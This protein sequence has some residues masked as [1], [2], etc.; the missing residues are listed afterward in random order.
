MESRHD[1]VR[2]YY[3]QVTA[4]DIGGVARDL[5]G[6]RIT[7]Q[8]GAELHCDCPHHESV[9]KRSLH[10][11][12]DQGLWHCFGCGIGGD[13]LQ[14]VEF[15]E[16]G[17]VT[18]GRRG[19]MTDAHR[20]A[21]DWLA[22]RVGLPPLS[23]AVATPEDAARVEAV[24]RDG[25]AVFAALTDLADAYHRAL[26][27][28][29]D[30]LEWLR[31]GWGIDRDVCARL[32]VGWADDR[33]AFPRLTARGHSPAAVAGTGAFVLRD[34]RPTPFFDHRVVFP[35]WRGGRVVY[36][37][38]RRTPWSPDDVE[39]EMGKYK[40]LQ[41]HSDR[42]PYVSPVIDNGVLMGEDVLL[43]RPDH[44][45]LA[46]GVTDW[47][48]AREMGFPAISPVT[49][50]L[51]ADDLARLVEKLRGCGTLY[52][53]QDNELSGVGLDGAIRSAVAL[54]EA[55]VRCRIGILPVGPRQ[56]AARA[57]LADM[58]GGPD[59]LDRIVH[60]PIRERKKAIA[61]TVAADDRDRAHE[62]IDE[63]KIDL[64]QWRRDG[65][66]AAGLQAVL[67][68]SKDATEAA[69]ECVPL[70]PDDEPAQVR[71]LDPVLR[72]LARMRAVDAKH[73]LEAI[74]DRTGVSLTILRKSVSEV[75]KV[76]Q[77]EDR[78]AAVGGR[79]PAMPPPPPPG[80][81]P[82][83]DSLAVL[84]QRLV[85]S[86]RA[87]GEPTP[88]EIMAEESYRWFLAHGARFFRTFD[89]TPLL[90]WENEVW[91]MASQAVGPRHRYQGLMHR[92]TGMVPT[93]TGPRTYYGALAAIA[94]DRGETREDFRWIESD[95]GGCTVWINCNNDRNEIVEASTAGARVLL[96][97]A[98]DAGV[99]LRGDQ[100]F[101]P[102]DFV[103]DVDHRDLEPVLVD[104]VGQHL[105]CTPTARRVLT[106]WLLAFPL[107]EFVGTRP[108]VRLEG[109]PGSGKTWAAK[110]LTT[111][112]YGADAQKKATDA[113]NWVDAARNPVLALDNVETKNTTDGLVDFLLTAITGIV[114]EKRASNTDSGVVVE[115][116][117]C[118]ILSTGVEPL[119][120][121]LEEVMSRSF[122][123]EF[124][125][126]L[127]GEILL[128][129][130]TLAAIADRRDW[131][132]SAIMHRASAVLDLV[133][134][135]AHAEVMRAMRRDLGD[136]GKR[137]CEEYLA[138]MYLVEVAGLS[139]S[140]HAERLVAIEDGFAAC[141]SSMADTTR[142][143]ARDAS[144]VA[145]VL[146]H[147][148]AHL[149][150]SPTSAA[151]ELGLDGHVDSTAR[152]VRD[153][154]AI[155]LLAALQMVRRERGAP[156]P[157]TNARQFG[158]R[159]QAADRLLAEQGF[160]L[161]SDRGRDGA[162]RYTIRRVSAGGQVTE[163]GPD[164]AVDAAG[165]P[166]LPP[167]DRA[168]PGDPAG[169]GGFMP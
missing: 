49:A 13:V 132:L 137:R 70:H 135:G 15:V 105:A 35:Y 18:A 48:A 133:R 5:L 169:G 108:M 101:L 97:G 136:H 92:L 27:D 162:N 79:A 21:R 91:Y 161:T 158:R 47:I 168:G 143:T 6:S 138:L 151:R 73:Y 95:V 141:V 43:G 154:R 96:N 72:E 60:L 102:F 26:L 166:V 65:G 39:W 58:L 76:V 157:W 52:L 148:F 4:V 112:V 142:R 41:V 44:V 7:E 50:R 126:R 22:R 1:A 130:R 100:K 120:A 165:L 123:V 38:G 53:V 150:A 94:S 55:G 83:S 81:A 111:I 3:D 59:V 51:K 134:R 66:D 122:V 42:R 147:L 140:E 115:R 75:A 54:G 61:A 107:L 23:R 19:E 159:L 57:E 11:S 117:N 90:F 17:S 155:E 93:S 89:G 8:S 62:L 118:L 64:C 78:R 20:R 160:V 149:E 56:E 116:P 34:D 127:Q 88:W 63:S 40:K 2:S 125:P 25:D 71:A 124:D 163:W 36:A 129:R 113:A 16:H 31:E 103:A 12:V 9:S 69:I 144:P 28:R 145:L 86:S 152:V 110:M 10:V 24:R 121:E 98:N 45:V 119:A 156:V 146:F 164:P 82:P 84:L 32:R 33:L 153:V 114:R 128:E 67:D 14:L 139:A 167:P 46:E 80:A 106:L 85:D 131:I 68:A 37:I 99:I 29:P 74:R 30:V 77:A 87:A 109:V 104:L